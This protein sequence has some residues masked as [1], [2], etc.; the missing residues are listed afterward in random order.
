[1]K[2][3][4]LLKMKDITASYVSLPEGTTVDGSDIWRSPVEV[5]VSSLSGY[6][7]E[8]DTSQVVVEDFFH[9]QYGRAKKKRMDDGLLTIIYMS[10][11]EGIVRETSQK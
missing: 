9:Q 5:K 11:Q 4:F 10:L 7:Q 6:L 2:M 8:P 3:Y 1:M